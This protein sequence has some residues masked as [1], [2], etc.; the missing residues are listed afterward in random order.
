[1][2]WG[3]VFRGVDL[4]TDTIVNLELTDAV[5]E[6]C[7]AKAVDKFARWRDMTA[8]PCAADRDA[9]DIMIKTTCSHASIRKTLIFQDVLWAEKF[10]SIWRS[11]QQLDA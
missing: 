7:L 11:E 1:M 4:V 8:K 3:G 10:L 9:P 6:Q 2:M 5:D